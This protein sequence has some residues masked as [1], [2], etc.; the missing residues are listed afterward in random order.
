MA[1]KHNRQVKRR[2]LD[3]D[4][5][6]PAKIT[7]PNVRRSKSAQLKS[8]QA[9]FRN[10]QNP[11]T[12]KTPAQEHYLKC[13]QENELTFGL[14]PAGVGKTYVAIKHAAQ[15]IDRGEYTALIILRPIVEAGGGLGFLP[16]DVAD[17]IAPWREP[18]DRVLRDH[19]GDAALEA[20]YNGARPSIEFIPLEHIRGR[21]FDNAIVVLDE[22]QNTTPLQMKTLLTRIGVNSKLICNGDTDQVDIKGMSGL[23]DAIQRL[24]G[25]ESIAIA[26]FTEEDV[27]RSGL[28]KRILMRYRRYDNALTAAAQA[29][30]KS[31]R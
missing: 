9:W 28:V 13:I 7:K 31:Q 17:K 1:N 3:S 26:S 19:Y 6:A 15:Q 29:V 30:S 16:G 24:D 5:P 8:D 10:Q 20:K 25:V 21:T 14:G 27:V 4:V 2:D 18:F 22:A 11:L 12:C 23:T